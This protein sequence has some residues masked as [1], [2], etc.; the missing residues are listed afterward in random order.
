MGIKTD[1]LVSFHFSVDLQG[2]A[3]GY[4][5]EVSGVGSENEVVEHKVMEQD[6][7]KERVMKIPG[8]LKWENIVCKRGITSAM[9][10]WVWRKMIED[11]QVEGAR[12]DGSIVMYD[13]GFREVARWNFVRGWP[14]KVTGPSVKS[15]GNEVGVEEMTITHE[16]IVRVK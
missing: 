16:G 14:A 1:P 3:L 11:G 10:M 9:D 13:E 7:H 2:A 5:T 6:G 15:D 12:K 4:F 8:R